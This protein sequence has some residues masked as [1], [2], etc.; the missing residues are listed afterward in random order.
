MVHCECAAVNA[1]VR[2][3]ELVCLNNHLK[4]AH[5]GSIFYSQSLHTDNHSYT[6]RDMLLSTFKLHWQTVL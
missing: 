4:C 1:C 3:C 6:V 2:R 5:P